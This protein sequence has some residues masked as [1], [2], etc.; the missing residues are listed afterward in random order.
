MGEP[1]PL[2]D[3]DGDAF[4]PSEHTRSP[5]SPESLHGGAVAALLARAIEEYENDIP[6]QIARMTIDLVRP[7][8][9]SPL[10]IDLRTIRP[11]G[12]VTVVGA[13]LLADGEPCARV[14]ALRIRDQAVPI[15]SKTPLPDD[16]VPA[17]GP[18]ESSE[19]LPQ[20]SFEAFHTHG[21][22][23]RYARGG[24]L[25]VGAAFA[26]IRLLKPVVADEAPTP[27]QR[28]VAAA[29]YGNGVSAV[30]PFDKWMFVNP[31]ITVHIERP[32]VGEWIGLD[33]VTRLSDRGA[34]TTTTVL[35]DQTG[36]V[37]IAVQHLL[38]QARQ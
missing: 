2:F 28:L 13:D 33:A 34:G 32:P 23:V 7:V 9:V 15:P 14:T 4:V 12:R 31:D 38:V 19:H 30:L 17:A 36:R 18:D 35:Y 22:E 8:P 21:C 16:V 6:M 24:W 37:G 29:D 27:M 5:W 20:W 10:T 11:G 1:D 26:W 3:R 25:E